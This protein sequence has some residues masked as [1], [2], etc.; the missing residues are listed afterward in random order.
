MPFKR[1]KKYIYSWRNNNAFNLFVDG[2]QYFP[3]IFSLIDKAQDFIIIEQYLVESGEITT[4]LID[5]LVHAAQRGVAIFLLFDD[6]GSLELNKDDRRRLE[7]ENIQLVF[8][9]PIRVRHLYNNL[10]RN[11]RK[12]ICIDAN[13]GFTGGAGFTDE[14]MTRNRPLGWH[15]VM[16]QISGPVLEDWL[17]SFATIWS[18]QS[19][20]SINLINDTQVKNTDKNMRG[21]LV[22]AHTPRHQEISRSLIRQIKQ[23]ENILWLA[24]PYFI[25]TRKLRREIKR[26]ARRSVDV[27]LLLP[28]THSD[29]PWVTHAYRNYYNKLLKSGVRVFEYQPR[30]LHA[31]AILCD[32]WVSI[33]S[34]NLDRWNRRWSMDANQEIENDAFAREIKQFFENDFSQC[35]EII[36]AVWKKRGWLQRLKEKFCQKI[37]FLLDMLGNSYLE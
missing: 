21:R 34:S 13:V 28:N 36:L 9:N 30:F 25:T 5:H 2:E 15:D 32:Q 26:A 11:H 22:T 6:Y 20:S 27:R 7:E 35:T 14:F 31:K 33:G 4:Q 29:H 12:I 37:V 17:T 18:Q 10:R 24:T 8:Y 3:H 23:S 16:L 1:D 19:T